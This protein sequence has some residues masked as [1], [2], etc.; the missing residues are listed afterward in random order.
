MVTSGVPAQI[1]PG[2]GVT[3]ALDTD[4]IRLTRRRQLLHIP[5]AA[6][7]GVGTDG[8]QTVV[9]TLT[10]GVTHRV[11]GGNPSA[12]AAF[13]T[14]LAAAQPERPD[15]RGSALTRTTTLPRETGQRLVR[16][17]L[18]AVPLGY[19]GYAG[20]V[21]ATHGSRVLG[22]I[23]G[24]FPLVMGLAMAGTAVH[25]VVRRTILR[26]RGIVVPAYSVGRVSKKTTR[27]V[28]TDVEGR[29]HEYRSR[30]NAS[31]IEVAYDPRHPDR[32]ASQVALVALLGKLVI[33]TLGGLFLLGLGA[34]MVFGVLVE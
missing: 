6:V 1:L 16:V 19:L 30:L 12:T 13:V 14:A 32:A 31:A 22:V 5:F 3:A 10:D 27:Y 34:V 2:R 20:W 8:P 28:Y 17:L 11:E 7:G 15:P 18:W 21:G 24:V 29:E 23:I 9:I 33:L 4:G 25:D 26:G